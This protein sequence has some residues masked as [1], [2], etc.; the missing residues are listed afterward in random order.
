MLTAGVAWGAY[1]L[2]GRRAG[3][4]GAATA[5][6]F[7]RSLPFVAV[8]GLFFLRDIHLTARGVALAL[9]S[10]TIASSLIYM[11]WYAALKGLTSTRAA[12]AQL[13][14]PALAAIGGIVFMSESLS[15][16]FVTAS[17][18]ILGGV[19]IAVASRQRRAG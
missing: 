11:I 5:D 6:N 1:S 16:R 19:A 15:V 18:M 9:F 12:I 4:A 8:V 3:D 17:V 13:S 14:V 7:A 10:G 2:R